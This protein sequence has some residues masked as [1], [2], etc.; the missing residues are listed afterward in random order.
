[1]YDKV[2][3]ISNYRWSL[4]AFQSPPL[5]V[6]DIQE[7]S[8]TL[9]WTTLR[10]AKF[11]NVTVLREERMIRSFLVSALGY[12]AHGEISFPVAGLSS[13][14]YYEV[15]MTTIST[16]NVQSTPSTIGINTS[17]LIVSARSRS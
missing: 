12:D 4:T 13:R 10:F 2:L 9:T 5:T 16:D 3:T 6:R 8:A 11:Y 15:Q 7:S 17:K 14:Q 1:M